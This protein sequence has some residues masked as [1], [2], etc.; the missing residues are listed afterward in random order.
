MGQIRGRQHARRR[1]SGFLQAVDLRGADEVVF[2]KTIH[3]MRAV[4]DVA[5]VISDLDVRMMVLAV[6][7]PG[8]CVHECHGLVV[9]LEAETAL[10]RRGARVQRPARRV[11]K[12]R[13][14]LRAV[15]G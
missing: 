14:R 3:C 1:G 9:V 2:R 5:A 6:R 12:Q 13:L 4:A 8:K 11:G 15:Q 10:D 7:H